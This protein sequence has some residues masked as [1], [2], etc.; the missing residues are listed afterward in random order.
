[1]RKFLLG[2]FVGAILMFSGQAFGAID[3]LVGKKVS[4]EI[5]V[6]LNENEIDKAIIV[7]GRSYLPVRSMSN[8][9]GLKIN[10]TREEIFLSGPSAADQANAFAI[11]QINLQLSEIEGL[12]SVSVK[13]RDQMKEGLSKPSKAIENARMKLNSFTPG[14]ERYAELEKEL[15]ELESAREQEVSDLAVLEAQIIDYDRQIR[16][17]EAQKEQLQTK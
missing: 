1:M 5:I 4:A 2:L 7:E 3:S 11:D 14:T 6:S 16:E 10:P 17:L 13:K 12:R 8:A 15:S 9:M